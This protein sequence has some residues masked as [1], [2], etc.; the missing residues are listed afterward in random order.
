M[1]FF[2]RAS[3]SFSAWVHKVSYFDKCWGMPYGCHNVSLSS[4]TNWNSQTALHYCSPEWLY[5]FDCYLLQHAEMT[6]ETVQLKTLQTIL[7]IFQS[8][9]HPEDEVAIHN[10]IFHMKFIFVESWWFLFYDKVVN[11]KWIW[12]SCVDNLMWVKLRIIWILWRRVDVI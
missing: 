6:D 8:H 9:M 7:I 4:L 12:Y 10:F 1:C 5:L 2:L 11:W 3:F